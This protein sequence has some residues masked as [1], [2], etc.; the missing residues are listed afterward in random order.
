[1]ESDFIDMIVSSFDRRSKGLTKQLRGLT[2]LDIAL[3]FVSVQFGRLDWCSPFG[4]AVL[5]GNRI[6]CCYSLQSRVW[7]CHNEN[8][9]KIT[10]LF[11]L[12]S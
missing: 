10:L 11:P 9:P 5:D 1:M 8:S 3:L 12:V 4:E 2:W 6:V 7:S